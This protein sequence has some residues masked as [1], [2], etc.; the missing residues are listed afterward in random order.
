MSATI[1]QRF[2]ERLRGHAQAGLDTVATGQKRGWNTIEEL[3][4]LDKLEESDIPIC[5]AAY[6]IAA[7]RDGKRVRD[8]M[9]LAP[10]TLDRKGLFV[11]NAKDRFAIYVYGPIGERQGGINS[12]DFQSQLS[13][14]GPNETIEVHVNSPGG[15]FT[16]GVA[17]HS[18]ISQRRGRT[19]GFVDG[20]AASAGSLI[21]MACDEVT[22]APA[23]EMMI[24]QC[25]VNSEGSWEQT[26]LER[27]LKMVK[28]TNGKLVDLYAVRWK[29]SRAE[30]EAALA[31]ETYYTAHE[32]VEVGLADSVSSTA[33]KAPYA[34]VQSYNSPTFDLAACEGPHKRF[35]LRRGGFRLWQ[36]TADEMQTEL[37]R[38]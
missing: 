11:S 25:S 30:L 10:N 27:A 33:T 4:F 28:D 36:L 15:N 7:E 22:M 8:R 32:A 34:A 13:K 23:G 16:E 5:L 19:L 2:I 3:K 1:A 12:A 17:I 37:D 21:L 38:Q 6:K 29:K 18:L 24:H 14:A 31:A 20:M 26:D 35:T 9:Y